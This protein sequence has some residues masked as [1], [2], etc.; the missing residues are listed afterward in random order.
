VITVPE[1]VLEYV[2]R[3]VLGI[4]RFVK[5]TNKN[6]FTDTGGKK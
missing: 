4:D 2:P 6:K 3:R 5:N 1:Y